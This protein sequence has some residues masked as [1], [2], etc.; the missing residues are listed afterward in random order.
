MKKRTF[1][2]CCIALAVQAC[3]GGGG[4]SSPSSQAAITPPPGFV[5]PHPETW[6]TQAP[7]DAGF[8]AAALSD[9]FNYAMQDGSFTQAAIVIRDGK[10]IEEQ[11]RGIADGEIDTLVSLASDPGA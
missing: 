7:T 9:A 4:G 8:N 10:L 2:V 3:G 5:S 1:L 6:E 11:Y